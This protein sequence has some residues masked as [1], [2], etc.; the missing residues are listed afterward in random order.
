MDVSFP[1]IDLS[2]DHVP[3]QHKAPRKLLFPLCLRAM[4][5]TSASVQASFFNRILVQFIVVL[6]AD[7]KLALSR[8][9]I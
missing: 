2:E 8:L 1:F 9:K 3:V 7:R 4:V 6:G 5:I